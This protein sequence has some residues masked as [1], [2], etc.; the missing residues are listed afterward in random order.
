MLRLANISNGLVFPHDDVCYFQSQHGHRY[1][2]GYFAHN[3]MPFSAIIQLLLGNNV[4][5]IDATRRHKKLTDALK[6]G[7]P[8]FS[9]VFNRAIY[10]RNIIVCDWQT[11]EMVRMAHSHIHKPLVQSIRKLSKYFGA[12][13]PIIIGENLVLECHQGFIGDD[14]PERIRRMIQDI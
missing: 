3:A 10:K 1:A 7:V 2:T 12:K 8:T 4:K 11:A 6:F 13:K 5:I 9:L 14:K